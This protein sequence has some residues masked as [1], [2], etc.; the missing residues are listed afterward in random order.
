ML[1]KGVYKQ[2]SV[3][4]EVRS[5]ILLWELLSRNQVSA[6]VIKN[7]KGKKILFEDENGLWHERGIENG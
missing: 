6:I 3:V 5:S 4:A 1:K 7:Q 2:L